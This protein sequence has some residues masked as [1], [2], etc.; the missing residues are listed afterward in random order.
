M[1]STAF[2]VAVCVTGCKNPSTA[3]AVATAA[4]AGGLAVADRLAA[5]H[6]PRQVGPRFEYPT[7][8]AVSDCYF[9]EEISLDE[10]RDLAVAYVNRVRASSGVE[11]VSLD[12]ALN[13]YAQA[14]SKVVARDHRPHTHIAGDPAACFPC[15]EEQSDPQ[16]LPPA[17][18]RDQVLG[19]LDGLMSAGQSPASRDNI[20][21]PG[22]RRIGVGI[23]NPDGVTY[24]TLDFAP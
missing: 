19:V 17:P 23:A 9:D 2:A 15:G 13:A 5:A 7:G 3:S 11:K 24:V 8:C 6:A 20:L 1:A 22:W 18:V 12:Y 4:V 10:A 16:G 14:G 21:S